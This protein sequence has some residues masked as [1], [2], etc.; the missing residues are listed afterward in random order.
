VSNVAAAR[1]P[2]GAAQRE[3]RHGGH[4]D[5]AGF[6]G[7]VEATGRRVLEIGCG[8]GADGV[9]FAAHGARYTGID[10]APEALRRARERFAA[11]G[12]QGELRQDD[13]QLLRFPD[14][15]FELVYAFDVL[16]FLAHPWLAI[17][18]IFRVLGPGGEAKVT[19]PRRSGLRDCGRLLGAAWTILSRR[20]AWEADRA[21]LETR[22]GDAWEPYYERFLREGWRALRAEPLAG[23]ATWTRRD[24]LALFARFSCA[25]AWHEPGAPG[26]LLVHAVK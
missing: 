26:H 1:A 19:L 20:R 2:W 7:F 17:D 22:P 12:V 18:E 10:I 11:A 24:A 6:A 14:A 25:R 8:E 23:G 15:S 9:M 21:R 13:A 5:V 16:R 4:R 3:P